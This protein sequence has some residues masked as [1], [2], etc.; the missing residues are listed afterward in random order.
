MIN[1][2]PHQLAEERVEMAGEYARLS[3][4]LGEILS[5]KPQEWLLLRENCKSDTSAEKK[6]AMTE[7]GVEET[8]IRLKL[9]AL[10]KNMSAVKSY[11]EVL[12]GEARGS[13]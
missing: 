1:K 2:T 8:L 10:E 11:L 3:E 4:K 12:Q 6:W 13:Y 9:K 7:M 5:L